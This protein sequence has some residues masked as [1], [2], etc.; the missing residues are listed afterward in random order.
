MPQEN[1]AFHR[2]MARKC[3][4]ETWDYL[5][6][7]TRSSADEERMLHLAHAGRFHWGFVGTDSNLAVGDW[8]VSRVYAALKNPSLAL[9]FAKAS[10]DRMQAKNLTDI[11]C[12]GYE[13]MARAYAVGKDSASAREYAKRAREQLAKTKLDQ[14]DRKIYLD[15]IQETERLIT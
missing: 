12:T 9:Q 13:A 8:Q 10:L 1:E 7:E 5:D 11:L 4:N 14:E 3:F 6:K 2:E 15:Q